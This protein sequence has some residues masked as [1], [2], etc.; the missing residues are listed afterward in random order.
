M[1][2]TDDQEI[3][4]ILAELQ[5]EI[6]RHRLALGD[7]GALPPPDPLARIREKQAVNPHLPIGWPVM[8]PGLIPKLVAYAQ[9]IVRRLLRWYINPIVA[10][11]NEFNAAATDLLASHQARLDA[12]TTSLEAL[13]ARLSE[14]DEH[15][16][17]FRSQIETEL[18]ATRLR[19]QRLENWRRESITYD[20]AS[21][22]EKRSTGNID[23]YL[24][25]ALYRNRYQMAERLHDY[26]DVLVGLTS[27]TRP[28]LPVLDIGCGRGEF[29]D[30]MKAL[31]L[32]AYG[33][34]LDAD[35]LAVGREQGL[36]LRQVDAIS[37]LRSLPDNGLS[38]VT[39]IQVAEHFEP[40]DLMELLYLIEHKLQPGGLILAETVNPECLYALVNWYLRDPSHRTPL[41]SATLRFLMMQAGFHQIET[42]FLHPVPETERLQANINGEEA[43]DPAVAALVAQIR[44]NTERLNRFLYGPQDY[45][46]LA[47]K[48]ERE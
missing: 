29:V 27:A 12:L 13:T 23:Y 16:K 4:A 37:H 48:P 26:D 41:H 20:E 11:Q 17:T 8:P 45:A 30:H 14:S 5:E 6:R 46:M 19:M 39:L 40:E 34:D 24:L 21:P 1:S 44:H 3:K 35:A 10:Q 15:W 47:Y 33:I 42:R 18:E 25:G 32:P 7:L 36:D 38:A 43:L 9:K 31:G 2:T 22:S 28:L